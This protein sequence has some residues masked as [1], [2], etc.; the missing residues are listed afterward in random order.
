[1]K[2]RPRAGIQTLAPLY[3]GPPRC[4][5]TR[6]DLAPLFKHG[7]RNL[8][9]RVLP[10]QRIPCLR[11]FLGTQRRAVGLLGTLSIGSAEADHSAAGDHR[12]AISKSR[13]FD[14]RGN[15]F[16]VMPIDAASRPA[17]RLEARQLVIR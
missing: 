12:R 11:D 5:S 2:R 1:M 3:P 13:L 9:R 10:T 14:G 7:L 16:G 6:P 4:T 8:E 15:G 17:R